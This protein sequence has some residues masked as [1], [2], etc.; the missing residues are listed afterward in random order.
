MTLKRSAWFITVLLF[1]A[2]C[3][4]CSITVDPTALHRQDKAAQDRQDLVS[5]V[6]NPYFPL[7]PGSR[8]VYEAKLADGSTE[9]VE[10]EIL[11]ET[12][13]VN[14][15]AATILHDSVFADGELIEET[16]DWYAQD[17]DGNVWY[18][19]EDVDNYE[20]GL[21]VDHAG[22]W[23]WGVDGAMPGVYMWADPLAHLDE[24]YYQEYYPGV[25]EDQGKVLSVSESITVPAGSFDEVVQTY[26][27]SA[28]DPSL[29][30][31][32]FYAPGVG[33]IREVDLTTGE[34]AVLIEFTPAESAATPSALV[35][36]SPVDV[37]A[38]LI[39]R[40]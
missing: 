20:N 24:A 33:V 38:N 1:L 25:A 10:L 34:E 27:F 3:M 32:K 21:L 35:E 30:E 31:H 16:F 8:W 6:D 23:E 22:S 17:Q 26:D 14:G 29:Q 15:V 28:M 9:R 37:V 4:A 12:R 39:F 40:H 2:V 5:V 11:D 36:L 7:I 18:L 13:Q 19:G